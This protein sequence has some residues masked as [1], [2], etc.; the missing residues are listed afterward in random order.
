MAQEEAKEK[1]A[2]LDA[3][4]LRAAIDVLRQLVPEEEISRL[5]NSAPNT[6]YTTLVTL[7]MLTL[8]RLGHGKSLEAVVKD[9]LA[10]NRELLPQNK[11][12]QEGTL[13]CSS[14]AYSGARQRLQLKTV[15]YFAQRVSDS[16]I[17]AASPLFEQRRMFIIDGTTITLAPTP[18]LQKA[19]PPATN[20][21]GETVWPVAL[22]MVAHE[23]Q[24][25]CALP[26]E[27]GAMYGENNTSEA[28]L[29]LAIAQKIPAGSVVLAD[30]GFG[31][32]AVVY[33]FASSGRPILFRL[34]KSR[35]KA[36]RRRA[37]LVEADEGG[38]T[39]ELDWTPSAKDRKTHPELPDDASVKVF[40]HEVQLAGG[41]LLY[42]VTTLPISYQLASDYYAR[43]YDVEHDIRDVKV[44]MDTENIRALSVDMVRKELLTSIVAYNLVVQFRRQAARQANVLPRELSFTRVWDTF[45][46]FLIEKSPCGIEQWQARFTE[47]LRLA[48][49][50][51]KLP[52]RSK[53]RDRPRR[54]HPRRPKSTKFIKQQRT[55]N[56]KAS[57]DDST[58]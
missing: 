35:F 54:A 9:V 5:Q 6:V 25:G 27:I 3:E 23:L 53:P 56:N 50:Y 20:Q 34:T 31:I 43:R 26:P 39:Y 49:Q 7:W 48:A 11:R 45:R 18:E 57:P 32:F 52:K 29:A 38:K 2:V 10:H 51:G 12:V 46:S 30:S 58:N 40:L 13:S 21:H 4:E 37:T 24:S 28:K 8:Q 1:E 44:A 55:E 41:E 22:L 36:L 19:F 42:L 15:E 14:A 16:L 47:A 33:H 17:E